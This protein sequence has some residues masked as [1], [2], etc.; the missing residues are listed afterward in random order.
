MRRDCTEGFSPF[1]TVFCSIMLQY[2]EGLVTG[3][4]WIH[5]DT[6]GFHPVQYQ[7]WHSTGHR[8]RP[9]E[10]VKAIGLELSKEV[11]YLFREPVKNYLADFFR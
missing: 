9:A 6:E 2:L 1:A 7:R 3:L 10:M 11:F 8:V 5:Q 4:H